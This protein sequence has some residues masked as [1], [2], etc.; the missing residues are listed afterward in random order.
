MNVNDL[1][2]PPALPKPARYF[3]LGVAALLFFL[4]LAFA[5]WVIVSA[6]PDSRTELPRALAGTLIA[7]AALT[8]LTALYAAR[9]SEEPFQHSRRFLI[10]MALFGIG[11]TVLV[12]T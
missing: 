8:L 12:A 3:N 4:M 5:V 7:V 6:F 11:A 9:H 1:R 2:S 10:G